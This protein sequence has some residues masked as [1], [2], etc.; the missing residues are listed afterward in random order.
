MKY[1]KLLTEANRFFEKHGIGNEISNLSEE[2]PE[3]II[4]RKIKK[5][6]TEFFEEKIEH[7]DLLTEFLTEIN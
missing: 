6:F 3:I 7:L 5:E 1:S 4:E 2:S